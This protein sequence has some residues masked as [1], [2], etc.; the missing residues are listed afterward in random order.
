MKPL[1]LA[2]ALFFAIV[3]LLAVIVEDVLEEGV[4]G[5]FD[6]MRCDR[7]CEN[8]HQCDHELEDRPV[9]QQPFNTW[10]NLA[11]CIVGLLP[12]TTRR[13]DI[14]TTAFFV[15]NLYLCIG[16]FMFHASLTQFW[17]TVD[18]AAMYTVLTTLAGHGVHAVFGL[19]WNWIAVAVVVMGTALTFLREWVANNNLVLCFAVVIGMLS[20]T[21][22]VQRIYRIVK[23]SVEDDCGHSKKHSQVRKWSK[24]IMILLV[25]T[26]PLF[27]F[28]AAVVCREMDE[29]RAWCDPESLIQGH[30]IWHCLTALAIHFVWRFFD[31]KH[32]I[33]TA[34]ADSDL[35]E[36]ETEEYSFH[37]DSGDLF[38]NVWSSRD[39]EEP[40]DWGYLNKKNRLPNDDDEL[41]ETEE[42]EYSLSSRDAEEEPTDWSI[43]D[44]GELIP[45]AVEREEI[46]TEEYS[47]HRHPQER[48]AN[49]WSCRDEEEPT[50]AVVK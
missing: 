10:T 32:H 6:S 42:E 1:L 13:L 2:L 20:T 15:A 25:A 43:V 50:N 40:T 29:K 37:S 24:S 36:S 44:T 27:L 4:W 38:A 14:S 47:C 21:L 34:D 39:E 49:N 33:P 7:Y 28:C 12:V 45:T 5:E 8:S 23:R 35:D 3:V 30:G 9:V 46:M 11:Y 26:T 31:R 19:R 48:L 16:S 17:A 22:T 18:A 41:E